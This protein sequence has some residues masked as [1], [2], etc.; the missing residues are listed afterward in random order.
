VLTVCWSVKGGA[1][2]TVVAASLAVGAS[3]HAEV[4]L[5]D[6]DGDLPAALGM[7]EPVG[8]GV[9]E[10]TRAACV[11]SLVDLAIPVR[12]RLSMV[13]RGDGPFGTLRPHAFARAAPN[14]VV[15]AGNVH[16]EA[17]PGRAVAT[18]ADRSLLVTRACYLAARR[19]LQAGLRP[20]GLV[21]VVEPGRALGARDM[22]QVLATP[23]LAEVPWDPAIA[24]AVD[25]GLLASR[26]P[27]SLAAS[28]R[29]CR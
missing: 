18:A 9:A 14:V 5:V 19:A 12:D 23:V 2:T 11:R 21:L 4:L 24:R 27:A 28:M 26:L 22:A 10:W 6:L 8:P 3:A 29:S 15:D 13:A 25:A 7:P 1:G 16:D 20:D 17:A